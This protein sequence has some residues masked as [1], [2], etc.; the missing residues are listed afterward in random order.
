MDINDRGAIVLCGAII[1]QAIKDA[2]IDTRSIKKAPAYKRYKEKIRARGIAFLNG[3]ELEVLLFIFG[4]DHLA[5]TIRRFYRNDEFRQ[6]AVL[7]L[8]NKFGRRYLNDQE[9]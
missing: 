1:N 3:E 7:P 2:E 6:L 5:D 8:K 4:C 9:E